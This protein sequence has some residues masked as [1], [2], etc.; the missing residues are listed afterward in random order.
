MKAQRAFQTLKV[1]VIAAA[2][3]IPFLSG[4]HAPYSPWAVGGLGV[5]ITIIEGL[6]QLYQFQAK[7]INYRSACEA[8]K[9]ERFLF[10]AKAGPYAGAGNP[11]ALLAERIVSLVS[12]EHAKW[13]AGQEQAERR[14]KSVGTPANGG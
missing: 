14:K 8:L 13:A 6:Q 4:L 3:V 2:A 1:I 5:L 11:R 9:H 7:W 12:H 10:V